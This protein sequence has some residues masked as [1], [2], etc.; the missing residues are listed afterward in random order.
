MTST[1]A[2]QAHLEVLAG[3]YDSAHSDEEAS[4]LVEQILDTQ[5]AIADIEWRI[6]QAEVAS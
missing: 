2:L 6:A 4:V 1:T 3:L 5:Q